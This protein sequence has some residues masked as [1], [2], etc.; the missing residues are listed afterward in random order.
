MITHKILFT[1]KKCGNEEVGIAHF[2]EFPS[3]ITLH[4][5][6]PTEPCEMARMICT[7]G[8]TWSRP[9]YDIPHFQDLEDEAFLIEEYY[10]EENRDWY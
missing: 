8:H 2:W 1:C 6:Y 3:Q 9:T 10:R 4:S 7:C 5:D